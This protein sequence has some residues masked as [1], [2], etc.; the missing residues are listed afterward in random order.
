[1]L[2]GYGNERDRLFNYGGGGYYNQAAPGQQQRA[3]GANMGVF[4]ALGPLLSILGGGGNSGG[5]L[6][7]LF[8]GG[9]TDTSGVGGFNYPG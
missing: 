2:R 4:G 9:A 5:G 8:G 6:G 3:M 7:S 1:M